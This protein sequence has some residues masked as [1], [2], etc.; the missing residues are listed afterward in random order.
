M[1][2]LTRKNYR[3]GGTL[4]A[5]DDNGLPV[6]FHAG[7]EAPEWFV[8]RLNKGEVTA[9]ES[10]GMLRQVGAPPPPPRVPEPPRPLTVAE[11][12]RAAGW[13][14]ASVVDGRV[15]AGP[16]GYAITVLDKAARDSDLKRVTGIGGEKPVLVHRVDG[17]LVATVTLQQMARLLAASGFG[18]VR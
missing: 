12:L 14:A 7:D 8:A 1:A 5:T 3:F 10:T 18:V 6:E 2:I 15:T 17:E 9:L 4:T 13:T 11:I 16:R